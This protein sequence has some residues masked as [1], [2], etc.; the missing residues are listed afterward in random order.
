MR[1]MC[2]VYDSKDLLRVAEPSRAWFGASR[3]LRVSRNGQGVAVVVEVGWVNG[4]GAIRSLARNG[5]RVL[6]VDHRPWA[7]GFLSLIHI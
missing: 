5:V 2:Q 4:L 3:L 1:K 7:L 6:A